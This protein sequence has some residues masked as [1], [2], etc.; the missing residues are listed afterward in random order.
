[1]HALRFERQLLLRLDLP[2]NRSNKGLTVFLE[3]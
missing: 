3:V 2:G 1:V